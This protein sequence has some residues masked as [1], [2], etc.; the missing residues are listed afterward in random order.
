MSKILLYTE[1]VE[2]QSTDNDSEAPLP[3]RNQISNKRLIKGESSFY[4]F[5][6]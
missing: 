6:N 3:S 1:E 5:H 2:S 4:S